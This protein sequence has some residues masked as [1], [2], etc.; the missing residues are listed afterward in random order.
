MGTKSNNNQSPATRGIAVIFPEHKEGIVVSLGTLTD[1][2]DSE[3]VAYFQLEEAIIS[4]TISFSFPGL[5]PY[6]RPVQIPPRN[7][8]IGINI[9]VG[10]SDIA[11]QVDRDISLIYI[12]GISFVDDKGRDAQLV[13]YDSFALL[14][15]Y[16]EQGEAAVRI[17]LADIRSLYPNTVVFRVCRLAAPPNKFALNPTQYGS[18]YYEGMLSLS[19]LCGQLGFLIEW[20]AGDYQIVMPNENDQINHVGMSSEVLSHS[21]Y[22]SFFETCNEPF[23]NGLDINRVVPPKKDNILR[24]SGYYNPNA[25]SR[26]EWAGPDLDY[27]TFHARRDGSSRYPKWLMDM[28]ESANTLNNWIGLPITHDE[29]IGWA[30]NAIDNKRVNDPEYA[31]RM[32]LVSKFCAWVTFHC[33][34]GL[35]SEVLT[36]TQRTCAAAF[37]DMR[38]RLYQQ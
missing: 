14:K 9:P 19:L 7:I 2:T 26:S 15:L 3:G 18:K 1:T 34:L 4:T 24:A 32:A 36:G 35:G 28:F 21:P 33:D 23:K 6:S 10:P 25:G 16:L 12:S 22:T 31:K 17:I 5:K 38:A 11:I 13:G 20:T 30:E 27:V 37:F 8:N 29:P